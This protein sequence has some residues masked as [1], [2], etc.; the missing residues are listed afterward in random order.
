MRPNLI[1]IVFIFIGIAVGVILSLQIRANPVSRESSPINQLEIQKSLLASFS[2]EQ[3][4]LKQKL[5]AAETKIAEA[6]KVIEKRSPPK[7]LKLLEYLRN[8]TGFNSVKAAGI[9][10]ILNDNPIVNRIDFSAADENFVQSTDLRDLVNL[11]FL[12]DAQAISIN[13]KRVTP[14]T[15]I[16]SVFDS[17]LIANYQASPPF[18]IEAA[19]NKEALADAVSQFKKRMGIKIFVDEEVSLDIK[20]LE[21]IPSLQFLFQSGRG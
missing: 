11:L 18:I 21:T 10:I 12:K 20:P 1:N 19:G 16:Q 5:T 4:D 15:A 2:L 14:F 13:G 6:Q 8:L 7:V 3:Q 9:R 17:I